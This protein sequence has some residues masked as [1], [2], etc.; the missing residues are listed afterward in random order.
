MK[1]LKITFLSFLLIAA[2]TS[3]LY[4]G[5]EP[6]DENTTGDDPRDPYVGD[7]LLLES[8]KSTESQSYT[9]TISKDPVNSSQVIIGN[10]GNPGSQDITVTGIVTS[11][12]VVVSSQRMSNAWVIEGSGSFT[13]VAKTTMKWDYS[14]LIGADLENLKATATLQ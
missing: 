7:W 6:V 9:I 3:V 12:Q 4:S 2:L 11:S 10:L 5:C 1:S 14:L 8:Y 13:N